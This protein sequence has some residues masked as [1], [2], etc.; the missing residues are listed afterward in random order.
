MAKAETSAPVC[1]A[2]VD[3]VLGDA[4]QRFE[5]EGRPAAALPWIPVR[6]LVGLDNLAVVAGRAIEAHV[7]IVVGSS[8]GRSPED[9]RPELA[10]GR[11]AAI[12]TQ[13]ETAY[14]RRAPRAAVLAL[15]RRIGA[16]GDE[17]L[18]EA[19]DRIGRLACS[20]RHAERLRQRQEERCRTAE[21]LLRAIAASRR[22]SSSGR[23]DAALDLGG[24]RSY[25]WMSSATRSPLPGSTKARIATGTGSRSAPR[26]TGRAV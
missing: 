11:A 2:W 4:R 17:R 14:R 12:V 1:M 9:C 3:P 13:A 15:P 18:G 20:C 6:Q 8:C 24:A 10:H 16:L 19:H 26:K 22:R 21:R 5:R 25:R 7:G 23:A